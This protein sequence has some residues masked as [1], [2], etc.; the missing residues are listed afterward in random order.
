MFCII[1]ILCFF[2]LNLVSM[3]YLKIPVFV[4]NSVILKCMSFSKGLYTCVCAWLGCV[5]LIHRVSKSCPMSLSNVESSKSLRRGLRG[6]F[7]GLAQNLRGR[8]G[9]SAGGVPT[10]PVL[11]GANWTAPLRLHLAPR[12]SISSTNSRVL[13]PELLGICKISETS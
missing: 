3:Y 10:S 7:R 9:L 2:V 13:T 4:K 11:S 5:L 1:L 8:S 12:P 6:D